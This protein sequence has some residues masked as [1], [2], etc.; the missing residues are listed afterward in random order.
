MHGGDFPS[1]CPLK[2][3]FE[4]QERDLILKDLESLT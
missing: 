1:L 2:W 3:D 4:K